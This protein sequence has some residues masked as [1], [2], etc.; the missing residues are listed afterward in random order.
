[1]KGGGGTFVSHLSNPILY[2]LE[3]IKA[4][5]VR[6]KYTTIKYYEFHY[7]PSSNN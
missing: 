6:Y 1:M 5:L 2:K 7:L 3:Q 4:L